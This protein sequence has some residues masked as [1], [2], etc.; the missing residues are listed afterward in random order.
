MIKYDAA[1]GAV[2]LELGLRSN[3]QLEKETPVDASPAPSLFTFL[4][5]QEDRGSPRAIPERAT[6]P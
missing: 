5:G 3:D 4:D 1:M 6:D 2:Y